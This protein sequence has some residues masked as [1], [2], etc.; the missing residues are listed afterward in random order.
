MLR[1]RKTR[2]GALQYSGATTLQVTST[3][4]W[5]LRL[6]NYCLFWYHNIII[7]NKNIIRI[8]HRRRKNMTATTQTM[9][10]PRLLP[11]D[12]R[13][14]KNAQ[15]HPEDLP[16]H[17]H[18]PEAWNENKP[19]LHDHRLRLLVEA[20]ATVAADR[21]PHLL[22]Q[23]WAAVQRQSIFSRE[24]A[25]NDTALQVLELELASSAKNNSSN[26]KRVIYHLCLAS[27][28][29]YPT[30]INRNRNNN[31]NVLFHHPTRSHAAAAAAALVATTQLRSFVSSSRPHERRDVRGRTDAFEKKFRSRWMREPTN[32]WKRLC[33]GPGP[34]RTVP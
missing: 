9:V 25:N 20:A 33:G 15:F 28:H 11:H 18:L 3:E 26:N 2:Q 32:L 21:R 29:H 27:P 19:S 13:L 7:M 1:R 5:V 31:S 8:N 14:P 22:H 10:R 24:L 6:I 16:V 4:Y 23:E 12:H 34:D 30:Y 17:H